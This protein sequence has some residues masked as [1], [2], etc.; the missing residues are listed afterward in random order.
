METTFDY[1]AAMAPVAER[2]KHFFVGWTSEMLEQRMNVLEEWSLLEGRTWG[3]CNYFPNRYG[4]A[5]YVDGGDPDNPLNNVWSIEREIAR[6][7]RAG[8]HD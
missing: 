6:R 5:P 1:E 3:D 2:V 4:E 7:E 8:E